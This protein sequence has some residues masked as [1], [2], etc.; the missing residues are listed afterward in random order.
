MSTLIHAWTGGVS[1][2]SAQ[3]KVKIDSGSSVQ[4]TYAVDDGSA[5][6]LSA[7]PMQTPAI[8]PDTNG[9][10]AFG[11]ALLIENT[12]YVYG[13][14]VDGTLLSNRMR[15]STMTV[16]AGNFT[17]AFSS[18][19]ADGSD[20]LVF[21]TIRNR[22]PAVFFHLGDLYST[23][24]TTNDPTTVRARY[25]AQIQAGTGRFKNL[26]ANTPVEYVWN[27]TDWGGTSGDQTNPA[28]PALTSVFQQYVPTSTLPDANDAIYRT[29]RI[30]RVGFLMLDVRSHRG[31]GSILGS[32]QKAWLKSELSS[33]SYALK[34]IVCPLP[35]RS[36]SDWGAFSAE[37]A[38][39]NSYMTTNSIYNVMMIGGTQH[40]LAADSGVHS[41]INRPNLLAGA[42]DG[43]GTTPAGTWDKGVHPNAT[44]TGQYGLLSF[45]DSGGAKISFTYSGYDE[46]NAQLIGPYTAT[47]FV[48][49]AP[50]HPKRWNGT[51][52]VPTTPRIDLPS[53]WQW[54]T[55]RT[56]DGT[57][58]RTI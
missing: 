19:Q 9:V 39:I 44:S 50:S 2:T 51:A 20:N 42:L 13:V 10:A 34:V 36:T 28:A 22:A 23:T 29:I 54:A 5:D 37:F 11:L 47:F 31:S 14:T 52:W 43:T 3:I 27:V 58:W 35:W 38:E 56:W 57:A 49:S 1:A 30:G 6:P 41:G 21:D 17:V 55:V 16:H 4:L 32:D 45:T 48:G 26:L 18:G 40:A 25:D 46:S 33:Y 15:F 53:G 12:P 8:I 24:V 7:S